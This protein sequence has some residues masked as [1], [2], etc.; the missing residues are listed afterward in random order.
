MHQH[1]IA[2]L[3]LSHRLP[4]LAP[5]REFAEAGCLLAYGLNLAELFRHAATY[6]DQILQGAK[7][8]D[9][10]VEPPTRFELVVNRKTATALGL[11]LPPSLL[12]RADEVLP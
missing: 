2:A 10:P 6:A 7:P 5:F 4:T 3:A 12:S 9:L 8:A 1:R 11:T